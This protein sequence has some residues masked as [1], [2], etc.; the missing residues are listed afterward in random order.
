[1]CWCWGRGIG[2]MTTH[3]DNP[4]REN[5]FKRTSF[6][7]GWPWGPRQKKVPA[8][9]TWLL[10][11]EVLIFF[12]LWFSADSRTQKVNSEQFDQ[13]RRRMWTWWR[14]M[15]QYR[16]S[17]SH[18]VTTRRVSPAASYLDAGRRIKDS[19]RPVDTYIYI[20]IY[21]YIYRDRKP[22]QHV[23]VG[24]AWG[25]PPIKVTKKLK[26]RSVLFRKT[27]LPQRQG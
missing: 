12:A 2:I 11:S 14:N 20:Y 8:S 26:C 23:T 19:G 9:L 24:L 22:S 6:D 17:F 13:R 7:A 4:A 10:F 18:K 3:Y 15:Y 27:L 1:M 25:S 16:R 5:L 21:I